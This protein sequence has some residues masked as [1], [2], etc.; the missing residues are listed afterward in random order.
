MSSNLVW[1]INQTQDDLRN[2]ESHDQRLGSE[3]RESYMPEEITVQTCGVSS[4][5]WLQSL[6]PQHV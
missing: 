3:Q 2:G 6:I 5:Q 1:S 4:T